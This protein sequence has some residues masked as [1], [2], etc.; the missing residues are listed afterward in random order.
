MPCYLFSTQKNQG[1]TMHE[2]NLDNTSNNSNIDALV[3]ALSVFQNTKLKKALSLMT[4]A[5]HTPAQGAL[6][7]TTV[8][9]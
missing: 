8:S 2:L 9:S 3:Q 5:K 4:V 6:T 1:I 7:S